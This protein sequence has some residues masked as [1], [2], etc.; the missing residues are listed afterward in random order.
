VDSAGPL[1]PGL[2]TNTMPWSNTAERISSLMRP[3]FGA[4]EDSP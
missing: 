1:L 4:D 2:L 3:L